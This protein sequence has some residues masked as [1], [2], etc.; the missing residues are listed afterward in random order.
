M[1]NQ[2][3][4]KAAFMLRE[5]ADQIEKLNITNC[6]ITQTDEADKNHDLYQTSKN[7]YTGTYELNVK[8][9]WK[10]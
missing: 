9:Q 4:K 7:P 5:I 2:I 3:S 10:K 8:L 1:E 6:K